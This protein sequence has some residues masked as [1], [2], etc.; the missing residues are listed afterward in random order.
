MKKLFFVLC[1]SLA[2]SCTEDFIESINVE[3]QQLAKIVYLSD[4]NVA[5][6][7]II[8]FD[9]KAVSRVEA[10]V[11]RSGA[12]RSG[13][14][15]FDSILDHISGVKMERLFVSNRFEERLRAEGMHR[16]YVVSFD[17]SADLDKAAQMFASVAEVDKVQY[18]ARMQ[19]IDDVKPAASTF[20]AP[21][22]RANNIYP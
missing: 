2:L 4:N 13:I 11:S 15:T 22:T 1:L 17:Q 21:T 20:N 18:N 7:L 10:G 14:E 6:S 8:R 16:W 12:T 5:G 19:Q 9:D 3:Q